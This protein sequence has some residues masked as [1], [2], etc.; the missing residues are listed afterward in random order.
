MRPRPPRCNLIEG[1]LRRLGGAA[2]GAAAGGE[3][4]GDGDGPAVVAEALAQ[5]AVGH[6]GEIAE[7]DAD[8]GEIVEIDAQVAVGRVG[9][10]A[11]IAEIAAMQ[12]RSHCL[13]SRPC[14]LAWHLTS[15]T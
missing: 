5:M 7:I 8:G 14:R 1:E 2:D 12:R 10:T 15:H 13:V 9:E 3:G 6:G 11:E 4:D